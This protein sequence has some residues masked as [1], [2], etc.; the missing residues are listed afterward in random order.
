MPIEKFRSI[1]DMPAPSRLR[2]ATEGIA[3]ACELTAT[4]QALGPRQHAPRGLRRFRSIQQANEH[5]RTWDRPTRRDEPTTSQQ[6]VGTAHPD[7]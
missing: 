3:A 7:A 4:T 6:A 2:S 5:R 1:E